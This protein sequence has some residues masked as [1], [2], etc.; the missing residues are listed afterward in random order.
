MF[1]HTQVEELRRRP[2][3]ALAEPVP[4]RD[5]FQEPQD[6]FEIK[7]DLDPIRRV[8]EL[9]DVG[10]GGSDQLRRLS[11]QHNCF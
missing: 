6:G 4:E 2:G 7:R 1:L 3:R 8:C 11:E 10:R 5:R 9:L